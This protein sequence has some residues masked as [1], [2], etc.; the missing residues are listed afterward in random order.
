MIVEE[1]EGYR[2]KF[3]Q[4]CWFSVLQT[5]HTLTVIRLIPRSSLLCPILIVTI[6]RHISI[7]ILIISSTK[8]SV[9]KRKTSF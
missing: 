1:L 6:L 4:I 9:L 7:E 3:K 2:K 5:R 8:S